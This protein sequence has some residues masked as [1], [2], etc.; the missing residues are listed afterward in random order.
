MTNY[1]IEQD[2]FNYDD[3]SYEQE[4]QQEA[5]EAYEAYQKAKRLEHASCNALCELVYIAIVSADNRTYY[6]ANYE[7]PEC[8]LFEWS[9]ISTDDFLYYKNKGIEVRYG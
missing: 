6:T 5:Q 4:R 7:C 8:G 1:D 9:E 2:H 3:W